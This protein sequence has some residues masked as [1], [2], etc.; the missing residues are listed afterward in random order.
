MTETAPVTMKMLVKMPAE[1]NKGE[2]F[3]LRAIAMHPMENGL[4]RDMDGKVIPRKILN[5]FVCRYNGETV[6][7]CD[8]GTAVA[9]NP[10]MA[11]QVKA[12]D[13]GTVELEWT[14]DDGSVHRHSAAIKVV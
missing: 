8:W 2:A 9:A 6:I 14:D 5:R 3:E 11:F 12:V 13:S 7:D 10:Y 1:A 4:R